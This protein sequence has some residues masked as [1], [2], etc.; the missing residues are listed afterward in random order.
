MNSSLI[1]RCPGC[2][3]EFSLEDFLE[4]PN[5]E[6]V[7]ISADYAD[8]RRCQFYFHHASPDCMSSLAVP[9]ER[10]LPKIEEMVPEAKLLNSAT[11]PRHCTTVADL[12]TCTCTCAVAPYRRFM[13]RLIRVRE[14]QAV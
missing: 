6:P 14:L 10:F 3:Q 5:L 8:P 4:D 12:R 9:V 11:C 2:G 1:K 13:L 7:G